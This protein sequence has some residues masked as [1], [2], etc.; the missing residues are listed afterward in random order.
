MKKYKILQFDDD[1]FLAEIYSKKFID[2]GF[3]YKRYENPPTDK[4]KLIKL[5]LEE[6][7]DLISMDIIMPK[8]DGFEASEKIINF[9][10]SV[11]QLQDNKQLKIENNIKFNKQLKIEN[12]I[13]FNIKKS[14]VIEF[15]KLPFIIVAHTS[16]FCDKDQK[17]GLKVGIT[18]YLKKS[19]DQ[20]ILD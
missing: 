15:N 13:K 16:I 11:R 19:V 18:E 2:F 3:D 4:E 8:I 1:S 17:K 14:K 7:P 10:L 6:E 9:T 12:N 5:V 20:N